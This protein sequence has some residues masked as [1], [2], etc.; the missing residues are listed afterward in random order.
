MD[1]HLEEL[2]L[3]IPEPVPANVLEPELGTTRMAAAK[4]ETPTLV[5]TFAT[6]SQMLHMIRSSLGYSATP[7]LAS[8]GGCLL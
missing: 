2:H 8:S 3:S 6:F 5:N 1:L 7:P 4:A